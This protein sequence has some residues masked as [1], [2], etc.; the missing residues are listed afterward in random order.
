MSLADDPT[1]RLSR[2]HHMREGSVTD[3]QETNAGQ[4]EQRAAYLRAFQFLCEYVEH[5]IVE[6]GNVE[7]YGR[8][9]WTT[10]KHIHRSTITTSTG[11]QS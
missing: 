2:E 1:S 9:T 7:C 8:S 3:V 11:H 4:K 10:Y 6:E 5:S